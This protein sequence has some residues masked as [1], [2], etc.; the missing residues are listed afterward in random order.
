MA[1]TDKWKTRAIVITCYYLSSAVI[2]YTPPVRQH[3]VCWVSD[4]R[5]RAAEKT[6]RSHESRVL[7]HLP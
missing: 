6:V 2:T 1:N 3:V 7:S 5:Q 4:G